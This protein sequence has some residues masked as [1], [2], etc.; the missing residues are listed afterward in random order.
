METPSVLLLAFNRPDLARKVFAAIRAAQPA[1]LFIAVDG[2]REQK[3]GEAALVAETRNLAHLV[4]WPCEVHTRFLEENLGCK[5]AVST[6]IN[7]FFQHVEEGVILEDD[8]EPNASFFVFCARMLALYRCDER[9]GMVSG[10]NFRPESEWRDEGHE[11]SR[12]T[13]IWGW[14][15][16]RRA[17]RRFDASLGGWPR[18][19]ADGWLVERFRRPEAAKRW[20]EIFDR[21]H[22]GA[23]DTWDYPWTYTCWRAGFWSVVPPCNLVSNIGFDSRGTHTM[24]TDGNRARLPTREL[25]AD[26]LGGAREPSAPNEVE[27]AYLHLVYDVKFAPWRRRVRKAALVAAR[28]FLREARHF[29]LRFAAPRRQLRSELRGLQRGPRFRAGEITLEGLTWSYS[30]AVSFGYAYEQIF[31]RGLY[32]F[33]AMDERPRIIDCGANLGL[34]TL[35]WKKKYPSAEVLAVEA[36]PEVFA[37]LRKNVARASVAGV[38]LTN[39]AVWHERGVLRFRP[40]GADGGFLDGRSDEVGAGLIEVEAVPLS[41]LVGDR[42]VDLLKLDVEGAETDILVNQEAALSRVRR[43]FV[44]HHSLLG[45]P[46]RLE[47]LLAVLARAGFRYHLQPELVSARP[48]AERKCD[49][50]MDQRLNIFAWRR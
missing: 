22:S 24:S 23:S 46:Q 14:A 48:F 12:F 36:D 8:C 28:G 38:T 25:A 39:R 1:R 21:C 20:R 4:D 45:R 41:E 10:N 17:W 49:S 2:A 5:Q 26:R 33:P 11:F 13:F 50:G 42:P 6:A 35:Y 15:T 37:Y 43:I 32:E 18:L 3:A 19:E 29:A 31:R 9:V 7:W 40:D 27:E 44:E 47:E 16:W 30:D 34:A